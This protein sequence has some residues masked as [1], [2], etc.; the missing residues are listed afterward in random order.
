MGASCLL[1]V[2]GSVLAGAASP[3][4]QA[5]AYPQHDRIEFEDAWVR[6]RRLSVGPGETTAVQEHPD[7]VL[8]FLTADLEGRIP[9]AE[10]LWQPEGSRAMENRSKTRFEALLVELKIAPSDIPAPLAP[11]L[12]LGE[13]TDVGAYSS[14]DRGDHRVTSLIDNARV[15][16]S[17][18]R[19][20]PLLR[21]ERYHFH[22]REAVLVYLSGGELSGSTAFHGFRRARRGEF[23]V[24]P[25]N[26]L[27]ALRNMGN[28][29]IE[30]LIVWPK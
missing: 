14:Y 19:L 18:H 8:V 4:S 29:P 5:S 20:V 1:I 11:E 3:P 7:G 15:T 30:F 27:H 22:P 2:L 21:T 26:T 10:A 16:V 28:D 13:W 6:V 9:P 17:R 12:A 24:L 23:D 25:A